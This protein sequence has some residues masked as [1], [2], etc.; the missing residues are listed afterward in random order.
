M[1]AD[2]IGGIQLINNS[3]TGAKLADGN[4]TIAKMADGTFP[5]NSANI[6]DSAIISSKIS[7]GNII[8]SKIA[9]GN[10]ITSKIADGNVT[11]AKM[12]DGTFP[13][14]AANL[15]TNSV[16]TVKIANDAVTSLKLAPL[17]N[18]FE[19]ILIT[20]DGPQSLNSNVTINVLEHSVRYFTSDASSNICINLRGDDS[21]TLNSIMNIGNTITAA[22][23]ITN[24]STAQYVQNTQVDNVLVVPKVQ[25]GSALSEG[26]ANSTDIY[27]ITVAKTA[28]ATFT[29]FLSQS[30]F[31]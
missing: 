15:A 4:V 31:A 2:A 27:T 7:D 23:L 11:I 10:V 13:V 21:T 22:L 14:N 5:V 30:Q 24:G 26:N 6:L 3:V 8:A 16:E 18:L 17:K 12:A 25:G 19:D 9:D 20:A 28:D 29:M 1:Q